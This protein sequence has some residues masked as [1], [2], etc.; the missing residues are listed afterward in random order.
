MDSQSRPVESDRPDA[1]PTDRS[2]AG[3]SPPN[4]PTTR[5]DRSLADHCL[6]RAANLA[7]LVDRYDNQLADRTVAEVVFRLVLLFAL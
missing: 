5:Y 6:Y 1:L 4:D 2:S 3:T 7:E